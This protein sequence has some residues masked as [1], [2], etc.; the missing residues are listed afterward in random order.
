MEVIVILILLI[1]AAV[2][3]AQI[4]SRSDQNNLLRHKDRNPRRP[5]PAFHP[6]PTY[7]S[8]AK[9]KPATQGTPH[10]TSSRPDLEGLDLP[11]MPSNL[12]IVGKAYVIDGDTIRIS[13]TKIRISGIDAPEVDMPWGQ[14][15]KWAMVKIC[16]GQT[17][18]AEL[19]GERSYDRLVA[20]CYLADGTDI[21]AEIIKQGHALDL[22]HFSG[23]KYRH[24][25]P[26]GARRRLANGKFG[27][28]SIK[29][30]D[31]GR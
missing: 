14:K 5:P 2:L 28:R 9:P 1:A 17:V 8:F 4:S 27:H 12:T 24:H 16:K 6:N 23:G 3:I 20:T 29:K 18:R 25:E 26:D 7:R 10:S 30:S 19:D 22:P 13:K 31:L 21:G 11:P 15:S